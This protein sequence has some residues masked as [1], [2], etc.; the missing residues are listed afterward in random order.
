MFTSCTSQFFIFLLSVFAFVESLSPRSH[1]A[2]AA[3]YR[4]HIVSGGEDEKKDEK[5]VF[6]SLGFFSFFLGFR[7]YV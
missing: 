4:V 3:A 2:L 1:L 6:F 5:L 7:A